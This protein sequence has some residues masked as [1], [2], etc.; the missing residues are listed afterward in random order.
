MWSG[1]VYIKV[2]R[3]LHRDRPQ[4]VPRQRGELHVPGQ[5]RASHSR[6]PGQ[7]SSADSQ[8]VDTL[9]AHLRKLAS[10]EGSGGV[11]LGEVEVERSREFGMRWVAQH[12]WQQ[13]GID[14][15]LRELGMIPT[16]EFEAHHYHEEAP[17]P[18]VVS[19]YPESLRN[20]GRF[21]R[22]VRR[23]R[24]AGLGTRSET[25]VEP[26]VPE[27]WACG[28]GYHRHASPPPLAPRDLAIFRAVPLPS[29]DAPA[30]SSRRC[31]AGSA[32]PLSR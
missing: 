30:A 21:T 22:R 28:N 20:P 5:G 16:A 11:C 18:R 15:L 12:L 17:A 26:V 32:G 29:A 2:R 7:T 14:R 4:G 10:P 8:K 19:H 1:R 27:D 3:R 6:L 31:P 23:G 25:V 13:L 24:I 9:S